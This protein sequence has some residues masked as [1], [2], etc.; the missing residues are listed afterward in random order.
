MIEKNW[1][2]KHTII[3]IK[4]IKKTYKETLSS[5][6]Y[7][8]KKSLIKYKREFKDQ[9]YGIKARQ[10]QKDIIWNYLNDYGKKPTLYYFTRYRQIDKKKKK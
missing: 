4:A 7:F 10:F 6:S 3:H 8:D 5:F 9:I 1:E 2:F